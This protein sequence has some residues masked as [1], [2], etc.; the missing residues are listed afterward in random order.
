[1]DRHIELHS[2]LANEQ[3]L[4]AI[5]EQDEDNDTISLEDSSRNGEL[6]STGL[7]LRPRH[8]ASK[9]KLR[10]EVGCFGSISLVVGVMIGAGIYSS[11]KSIYQKAGSVGMS[12]FVWAGAGVIAMF[13]S[14]CY[15]ELGTTIRKSGGERTYLS[16]VFGGLA[17]FMYS[18]TATLIL[19]PC[20]LAAVAVSLAEYTLEPFQP[21]CE[22][23]TELG[24]GELRPI[25]K[26]I[27]A[28]AI[29]ESCVAV[30]FSENIALRRKVII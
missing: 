22:I 13:S 23:H 6:S 9:L 5:P 16:R 17:G 25:A 21:G 4:D 18:W 19:K 26:L 2:L 24:K 12:L 29:G 3:G 10:K 15:A 8:Y 20:G 14:L 30:A 27:A 1:M 7:S 11:N 28:L